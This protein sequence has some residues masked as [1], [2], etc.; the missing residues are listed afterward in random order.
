[1]AVRWAVASFLS[2]EKSCRRITGS[3][4]LGCSRAHQDELGIPT[5]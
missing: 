2:V 4:N 1:M 3:K 5:G